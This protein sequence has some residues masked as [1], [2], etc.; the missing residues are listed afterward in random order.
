M[1]NKIDDVA[2]GEERMLMAMILQ[3]NV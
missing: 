3:A 2:H 1:V